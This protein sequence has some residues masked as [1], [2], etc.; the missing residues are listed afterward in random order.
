MWDCVDMDRQV[1]KIKRTFS[2]NGTNYLQEWTKTHRIR[3]LPFTDELHELFKSLRTGKVTSIGGFVFLNKLGR[4][5]CSSISKIWSDARVKAACPYDVNLYQG[6]R[7][8]FATQHLD[9]LD[10]VRQVLGHTRTDM[11]RRYQGINLD[12]IKGMVE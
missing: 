5:Y 12:A 4:P 11:T 7:H 1:I 2:G 9:K 3:Y 10:L 8:S 6:T